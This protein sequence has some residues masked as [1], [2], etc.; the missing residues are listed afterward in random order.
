MLA[1]GMHFVGLSVLH[2]ES[3]WFVCRLVWCG[4]L[5]AHAWVVACR[6]RATRATFF[7]PFGVFYFC[8]C[9]IDD[10]RCAPLLS[11]ALIYILTTFSDFSLFSSYFMAFNSALLL[12]VCLMAVNQ[13]NV[14]AWHRPQISCG[15]HCMARSRLRA[16]AYNM[17]R[18]CNIFSLS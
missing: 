4:V 8:R 3:A 14:P 5:N 17:Q 18:T 6:V 12:L 15:M 2:V 7:L 13:L 11:L 10:F 1:C 16:P 9:H